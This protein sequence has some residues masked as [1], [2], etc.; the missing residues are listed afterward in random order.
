MKQ[1]ILTTSGWV[2]LGDLKPDQNVDESN[3]TIVFDAILL[4]NKS[5]DPNTIGQIINNGIGNDRYPIRSSVGDVAVS[6]STISIVV[7]CKWS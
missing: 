1:M 7:P 3:V 6:T 5:L 2:L 4:S